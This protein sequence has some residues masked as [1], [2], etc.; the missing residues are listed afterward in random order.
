MLS[1]LRALVVIINLMKCVGEYLKG[2]MFY[3]RVTPASSDTRIVTTGVSQGSALGPLLLL[4]LANDLPVTHFS[5]SPIFAD[6]LVAGSS[7]QRYLGRD[8]V[9]ELTWGNMGSKN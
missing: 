7:G 3:F 1:L 5:A 2:K 9:S 4:P 6:N 8:I